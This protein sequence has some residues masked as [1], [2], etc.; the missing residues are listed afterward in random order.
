[1]LL[2]IFVVLVAVVGIVIQCVY[3]YVASQLPPLDTVFDL[4][5]L[6]KF[7]I[8]GERMSVKMGLAA[9]EN[10]GIEYEPPDFAHLPK[11]LVA[12]YISQRGCPT[13]FQTPREEGGKWLWRMI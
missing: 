11:D 8:E 1:M 3:F 9:K 4:Q 12:V 2:L 10:G 6:L 5:K 13:Y 7:N